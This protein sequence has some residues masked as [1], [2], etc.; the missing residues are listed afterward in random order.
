MLISEDI[1]ERVRVFATKF[2]QNLGF[3]FRLWRTE[4]PTRLGVRVLHG[5][6][7]G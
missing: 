2:R 7:Q 5:Y 4:H 3:P 6:V 1:V